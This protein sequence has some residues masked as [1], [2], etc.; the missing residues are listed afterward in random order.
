MSRRRDDVPASVVAHPRVGLPVDERRAAQVACSASNEATGTTPSTWRARWVSNVM[1]AS[2]CNCGSATYSATYVSG[3]PS[4]S[5]TSHARRW[6]TVEGSQR[7]VPPS[8]TGSVTTPPAGSRHAGSATRL[9][10]NQGSSAA[11]NGRD[12]PREQPSW[13]EERPQSIADNTVG[14]CVNR[15]DR[16]P[17][18]LREAE[19]DLHA[20]VEPDPA[21]RHHAPLL[22]PDQLGRAEVAEQAADRTYRSGELVRT[23]RST[24]DDMRSAL[25]AHD[26][27]TPTAWT[28]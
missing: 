4:F 15:V 9:L 2:A 18:R 11:G 28:S 16:R 19:L 25:R 27:A 23:T 10:G 17:G 22:G 24:S 5:A 7:E 12:Q 6:A 1:N 8:P 21:L 14:S 26:P 13:V 3:H 20:R